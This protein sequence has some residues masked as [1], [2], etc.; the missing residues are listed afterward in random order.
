MKTKSRFNLNSNIHEKRHCLKICST[1]NAEKYV[2]HG[3]LKGQR[4]KMPKILSRDA[5]DKEKPQCPLNWSPES[6]PY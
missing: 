2:I 3:M 5:P 1:C 4:P 6:G